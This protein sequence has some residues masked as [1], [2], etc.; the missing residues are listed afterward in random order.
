MKAFRPRLIARTLFFC[1]FASSN[2]LRIQLNFRRALWFP[3][4]RLQTVSYIKHNHTLL[5]V[6]FDKT[7][8]MQ[9]HMRS[10]RT[11]RLGLVLVSLLWSLSV[12]CLVEIYMNTSRFWQVLTITCVDS[13]GRSVLN[14]LFIIVHLKCWS[15]IYYNLCSHHGAN[16]RTRRWED[17]LQQQPEM[18]YIIF[19]V[20]FLPSSAL[21]CCFP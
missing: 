3:L 8:W 18:I 13:C 10:S 12:N 15:S 20:I 5:V 14:L 17:H 11:G 21:G 9:K 7:K 6:C 4:R 2:D 16:Q 19:S 1:C